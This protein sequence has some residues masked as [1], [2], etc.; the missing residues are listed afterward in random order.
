MSTTDSKTLQLFQAIRPYWLSLLLVFFVVIGLIF[1]SAW[2]KLNDFNEYQGKLSQSTAKGAAS[3]ISR[4][5]SDLE[6]Q[7]RGFTWDHS[8]LLS[9]IA[10]NSTV[11]DHQLEFES[12]LENEF[13]ETLNY[14]ISTKTGWLVM[15]SDE[16]EIGDLCKQD[17]RDFT[18]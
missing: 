1:T 15:Q 17:I 12:L 4:F 18:L 16:I 8:K 2:L 3:E 14:S 11:L 9:D 7:L 10:D 13:P 5:I 6:R